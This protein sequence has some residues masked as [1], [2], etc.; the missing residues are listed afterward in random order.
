VA[1][2]DPLR[3]L[4]AA[5]A[6]EPEEKEWMAGIVRAA[7]PYDLGGGVLGYVAAMESRTVRSVTGD[8]RGFDAND[9]GRRWSAA[10]PPSLFS[11]VHAP[12]PLAFSLDVGRRALARVGLTLGAMRRANI[13]SW[14]GYG[15]IGGDAGVETAL[16]MFGCKSRRDG[17]RADKPVLD[18]VAA[19]VGAAL[20]LRRVLGQAPADGDHP[21]TEAVVTPDGRVLDARGAAAQRQR[22]RLID[23]VRAVDRARTRRADPAERMAMWT[24]LVEGRWSIV[25]SAERDG[26]RLLLAC[27]NE[28]RTRPL[29]RLTV[30][31]RAVVQYVALGHSY[32]YIAYE[33]GIS[34]SAVAG[35]LRTAMRKLGLA[36]RADVIRTFGP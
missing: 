9:L 1:R 15:A 23:A 33:L 17:A 26:K 29:R 20:R 16:L 28:P 36:T 2:K 19:H 13:P 27:R 8:T 32:K 18:G 25:E 4:D 34:I 30:R 22:P 5:Y 35:N 14:P 21:A 24:A 3:I 11:I 7:A 31:E 10:L 6:F 12:S